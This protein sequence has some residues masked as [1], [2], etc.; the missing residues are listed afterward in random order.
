[1]PRSNTSWNHHALTMT[2]TPTTGLAPPKVYLAP[3]QG[4]MDHHLRALV[5]R[6][7]GVDG[8]VTEFIRVT[9]QRLPTRVFHRYCPELADG[10]RTASGVPVKVQLLGSNPW[11]LAV[12]AQKA[13]ALGASAIDLN[14]GCPAKTVNN[15]AGGAK[16]LSQ[17][18]LMY[19]IVLAVRQRLPQ[20]VPL[21]AKIRLGYEDRSRYLEAAEAA[22]AGGADELVVHARSKADGYR[23]PAYWR[24]IDEIQAALSIPV[25]ANGE[26]WSVADWQRCREQSSVN[27]VMLGRGML[28]KP[29]LALAIKR[30]AA[31]TAHQHMTWRQACQLLLDY[32]LI[33]RDAY[34]RKFLGN[35]VKQWLS[36]LQ[37]QFCEAGDFLQCIKRSR[38]DDFICQQFEQQLNQPYQENLRANSLPSQ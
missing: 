18:E 25:V 14:F 32:H 11:A 35:R 20:H 38:D 29:D 36:Y 31:Q 4:V 12:N 5:T 1:M 7:G 30:H 10:A 17:P 6:L 13:A 2:N 24:Y 23:P 21:S 34:P 33:T 8:C 22:A 16:L 3:M 26:V 37:L 19:Q 15:S 27:Q 28:A 9:D